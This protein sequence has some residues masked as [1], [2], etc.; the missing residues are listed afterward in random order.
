MEFAAASDGAG[1]METEVSSGEGCAAAYGIQAIGE[2]VWPWAVPGGSN[3]PPGGLPFIGVEPVA[4]CIL[5]RRG[6]IVHHANATLPTA[7]SMGVR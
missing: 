7:V 6:R 2:Y 1:P 4:T 3:R 5:T